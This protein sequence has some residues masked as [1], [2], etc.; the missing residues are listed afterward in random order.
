MH[1]DGGVGN[2]YAKSTPEPRAHCN[3]GSK[4]LLVEE[5]PTMGS[6]VHPR[7]ATMNVF[8]C[9]ISPFKK[10]VPPSCYD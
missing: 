1:V 10:G 6:I 3:G 4:E 2:Q 8:T 9:K 7:L 5:V